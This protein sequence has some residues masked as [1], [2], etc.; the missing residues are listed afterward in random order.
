M[1]LGKANIQSSLLLRLLFVLFPITIM[2]AACGQSVESTQVSLADSDVKSI[3]PKAVGTAPVFRY[4]KISSGAYFYTGS[5]AEAEYINSSL[6]DFRYEGVAFQQVTGGTGVPVYR[7]AKLDSGG[8]FYTASEIE[9]N[10]VISLYSARFRFE[11]E[12]FRV[13]STGG[14]PTYRLANANNGAYLYTTSLDEYNYAG[15]LAGWRKE[16]A[17]FNVSSGLLLSGTVSDGLPWSQATVK[18]MD[19]NGINRTAKTGTTGNYFVDITGLQAPLV[20]AVTYKSPGAI[21]DWMGAVLP[22]L[23]T[24]TTSVTMNFT[25]I[26]SVLAQYATSA[27][28]LEVVSSILPIPATTEIQNNYALTNNALRIILGNHLNSNGIPATDYDPTK[29][30][31]AANNIGQSAL[32]RD[33][34]VSQVGFTWFTNMRSSDPSG[35]S[36]VWGLSAMPFPV[37]AAAKPVFDSALINGMKQAWQSCL[38]VPATQR[39]VLDQAN[40]VTTMHPS[41][42]A[43]AVASYKDSGKSFAEKYRY[44]LSDAS[45]NA[46]SLENIQQRGYADLDGKQT[47]SVYLRFLSS[48]NIPMNVLETLSLQNGIWQLTGDLRTYSGAIYARS[49]DSIAISE[50]AVLFGQESVQLASLF[51]PSHPSMSNI[52]SVRVKGAGLPAA[53]IVLSRSWQCGTSEFMAIDNKQ[54]LLTSSANSVSSNITYTSGNS[55]VFNIARNVRAGL[56]AW[57]SAGTDRNFSDVPS[58]DPEL[59][60]RPF[61]TYSVEYFPFTQSVSTLPV[62]VQT[63]TLNGVIS[64]TGYGLESYRASPTLD[65]Q[66]NYMT[67][68]GPLAGV[69]T[70]INFAWNARTDLIPTIANI[71]IFSS[72]R[73]ASQPDS[74]ANNA[75]IVA[76]SYAQMRV[77]SGALT[78]TK[79]YASNALI[80]GVSANTNTALTLGAQNSSC[81]NPSPNMLG[82]STS[83]TYREFTWVVQ[84]GDATQRM[85]TYSATN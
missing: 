25:P 8:Y 58:A 57:P 45:F 59:I 7:F 36:I 19:K 49:V 41:C 61:S 64:S 39:L 24:N 78:A 66:S 21:S 71:E 73:N 13:E 67:A 85:F 51:D 80:N 53:G 1:N 44:I 30:P 62:A 17:A 55:S 14:Q 9:K 33:V 28:V 83:Q 38:A 20:G 76:P 65:F 5:P 22:S 37:P 12:A 40:N 50:S 2:I 69:Q 43:I 60:V 23:P 32:L 74:A 46:Q 15:T 3:S 63:L 56:N 27:N 10:Q 47:F 70:D 11:G 52:R 6:P 34:K 82:L 84:S 16:G 4:A 77:P 26:T 48:T 72:N 35:A 42:S 29:L 31:F 18:I 68:Y 79:R 75:F 54:G 81:T